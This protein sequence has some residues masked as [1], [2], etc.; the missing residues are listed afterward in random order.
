MNHS[1]P[2][3]LLRHFVH[4]DLVDRHGATAL[5]PLWTLL[6]PLS[7]ILIFTLV[8]SRIM[9]TRLDT[10]G[11]GYLG[12][13]GYSVYLVSG[14]LIWLCFVGTL[15]RITGVYQEKAGLLGKVQL[16]LRTLPLYIVA[17]ELIVFAISCA[18]FVI[19][20]W[21]IDFRWSWHWLWLPALLGITQLL[22]YGLGL[23]LATLGVFLRDTREVVTVATQFWFW[24][25]PI[26]YVA[27]IIPERWSLLLTANPLYH[28][29][30]ATRAALV[31]GQMPDPVSLGGVLAAAIAITAASLWLNRRM[32]RDI[33]DLL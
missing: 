3:A 25:T 32:E 12:S 28:I 8:F 4:Q 7:N 33:R 19:F 24:L 15:T 20:L 14:L 26:V 9:A 13:Y 5:G 30:T 23:L 11:M 31:Q 2:L 16:S 21:L 6:L 18:F 29:T 17:S 22:A 27:D 10:L 1:L